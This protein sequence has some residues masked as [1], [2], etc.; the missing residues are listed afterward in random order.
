MDCQ[1]Q[2]LCYI[3]ETDRNTHQPI[4]VGSWYVLCMILLIKVSKSNFLNYFDIVL[5]KK[6]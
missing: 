6:N 1:F 4:Y 5:N 2:G 3:T